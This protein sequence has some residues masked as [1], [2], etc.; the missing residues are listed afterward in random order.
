MF[1]TGFGDG[2]YPSFWG[3]D[4]ENG[5]PACLVTDFLIMD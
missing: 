1:T 5:E 3:L 2:M 4:D